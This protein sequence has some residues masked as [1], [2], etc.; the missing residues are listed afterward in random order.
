MQVYNDIRLELFGK[1]AVPSHTFD[2]LSNPEKVCHLLS[3]TCSR[4]IK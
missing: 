4:I 2:A 3:D 1:I